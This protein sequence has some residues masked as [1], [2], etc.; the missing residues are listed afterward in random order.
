[1][2]K[3]KPRLDTG[4]IIDFVKE[5]YHMDTRCRE[6]D[7]ERDQNFL[8][9][10]DD[11]SEYILKVI[12]PGEDDVFIKARNKVF[13]H[14]AARVSFCPEVI[15]DS[16]GA[17]ITELETGELT[18][19]ER[20]HSN[21]EGITG[22][23]AEGKGR[24]RVLMLSYIKGRPLGSVKY[25]S[26]GLL[27]DL[28]SKL[29]LMDKALAGFY[30][31][32]FRREFKWDLALY[33]EVVRE[34]Y[35]LVSDKR[36][37]SFIDKTTEEYGS[38]VRP[39]L[40][41]LRRSVIH[42]DINDYNII[43]DTT[44]DRYHEDPSVKGFI[45]FGD[46]VYSYT[47][48]N[49]A[50][51][52]AYIML[53]RE[54]PL[55]A[56]SQMLK[57]YDKTFRLEDKEMGLIFIMAKMRLCLSICMAAGQQKERPGDSYLAISQEP[58]KDIIPA[59]DNIH[60]LFA[61][62][63]FR[64]ACG[65]DAAPVVRALTGEIKK[66]G[67]EA[68]PVLGVKPDEKNCLVL[69]LG[70]GSDMVEGEEGLNSAAALGERID[71]RLRTMGKSIG[72]GRF[73]EPRVL[74]SSPVFQDRQFT[75]GQDRT[76]H[77][78]IDLF[79]PAGTELYAPLDGTVHLFEY[80]EGKLDYGHM[81]ILS[82]DTGGGEFYTLYGH[83]AASS[84]E[85][86]EEGLQIKKGEVFARAGSPDE[87]GG[88]SPH[89][90]FQIITNMMGYGNAFP[91]VC[92]SWESE[93]WQQLSP[94]PNILLNIPEECFPEKELSREE[95]YLKRRKYFGDNLGLSYKKP[96]KMVRGWRQFL[97]D[98][99]GQK[100]LDAYNNVPHIGHSH[101][102]VAEAVYRQMKMLNTNTRY[103]G[104]RLNEYAEM[105]LGTFQ[106]PLEKCFFLNS[107][108][109]ANELALRLAYSYTGMKD[110]IVLE[111][112]YHGNTSTLID[113]SPYKHGG[114]GG[115]GAPPWVHTAEVPD[116]YRGKYKYGSKDAGISYA[117]CVGQIA[118]R[119]A[120]EGRPPAAFIAETCPSVGGQ[121]IFPAGYLRQV[122]EYMHK[123]GAVCIADEVQTGYGRMG[124]SFYAF[125]DQGVTPDIVVLGKP[126]GNGHPL[127]AVITTA[128]IAAAFNNGMEFFS[129]F[130]GNTVSAAAGKKVLEIVLRD[131]Y[132]EH[133]AETGSYLMQLLKPL[134]DKYPLVGDIRGS[135][136]F[137]GIEL[138]RDRHTLEPA[139]EEAAYIKERMRDMKILMGTDG[140]YDN[141]LK[142]RPPMPFSVEDADILVDRLTQVFE[143]DPVAGYS[144]VNAF[145]PRDS[146]SFLVKIFL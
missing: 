31:E 113:I 95:A 48:A 75:Y 6:L 16:T 25:Q 138:V 73:A 15:K 59:L 67:K 84:F 1:M 119:L 2:I 19:G 107:A 132:M 79:V 30:D 97:F 68:Y 146:G 130:G 56:A 129:T 27:T 89:L 144:R 76:V 63:V 124:S 10:T 100:Y 22:L 145:R 52:M 74:Y 60:P 40:P 41:G 88:W 47:A 116:A 118:D 13:D 122:Y 114:P 65:R 101:P 134:K 139:T 121:I 66:A 87:N 110:V 128:E 23:E 64:R 54:D 29:G 104:D 111:G 98:E 102:E 33:E 141:V 34:Y 72:I 24:Y 12:N 108:S 82:H 140:P 11:G 62:T 136:L 90:H 14:L 78:G 58:I 20:N 135:G 46:M 133:A 77:L 109:E 32:A 49:P 69:D 9:T 127:A 28:G 83:L 43:V 94:H 105:L 39:A 123:H 8:L 7:G 37:R 71:A 38:I 5:R 17:A 86:L 81:I 117:D 55:R 120:G 106:K 131:K 99:E 50:I 57:A 137:L 35:D 93:A 36:L 103:L 3:N 4:L 85:G 44:T 42:N 61:E 45:D 51:A 80:N 18:G 115:R 112:A 126:I 143:N 70:V 91:G 53:D 142:I 92:K 21:R 26:P 125:M 96:L